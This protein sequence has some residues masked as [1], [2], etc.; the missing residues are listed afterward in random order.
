MRKKAEKKTKETPREYKMRLQRGF[1]AI[2]GR[3][4][5]AYA[6]CDAESTSVTEAWEHMIDIYIIA[7]EALLVLEE[8]GK[9]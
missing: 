5:A 9:S 2:A 7:H 3:A 1:C 6:K 8:Q 4:Q